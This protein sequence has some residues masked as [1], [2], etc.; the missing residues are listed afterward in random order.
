MPAS[1]VT[2]TPHPLAGPP[3][4]TSNSTWR[5]APAPPHTPAWEGCK[6]VEN[7]P[8]RRRTSASAPTPP[9]GGGGWLR[10]GEHLHLPKTLLLREFESSSRYIHFKRSAFSLIAEFYVTVFFIHVELMRCLY[11]WDEKICIRRTDIY[12][13]TIISRMQHPRD[14]LQFI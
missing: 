3:L 6:L 5:I 12:S 9:M 7:N 14:E 2:P 8:S 11:I 10:G 1:G 4:R 13:N